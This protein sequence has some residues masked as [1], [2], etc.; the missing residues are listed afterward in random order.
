MKYLEEYHLYV[1]D[2]QDE[3]FRKIPFLC[4]SLAG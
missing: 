2:W 4:D 3:I 1:T